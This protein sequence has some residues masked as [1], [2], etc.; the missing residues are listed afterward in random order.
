MRMVLRRSVSL[1]SDSQTLDRAS[2]SAGAHLPHAP[3]LSR[4]RRIYLTETPRERRGER[5]FP[6]FGVHE[7]RDRF[8]YEVSAARKSLKQAGMPCGSA[9]GHPAW[10][11]QAGLQD[12]PTWRPGERLDSRA[13]GDRVAMEP[14]VSSARAGRRWGLHVR[15]GEGEQG[16]HGGYAKSGLPHTGGAVGSE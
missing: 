5:I 13:E 16:S 14:A 7:S 12:S 2:D 1:S 4:P 9:P 10:Q 15:A 6:R 3:R 11:S 8:G